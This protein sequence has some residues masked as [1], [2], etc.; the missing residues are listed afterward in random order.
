LLAGSTA[1][2][3][4]AERKMGFAA[5]ISILRFAD[6]SVVACSAAVLLRIEGSEST[7]VQK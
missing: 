2:D 5:E 4:D 1:I 7:R 6:F 3:E